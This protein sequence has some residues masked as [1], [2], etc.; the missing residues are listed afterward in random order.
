MADHSVGADV[1]KRRLQP[2]FP[3][4]RVI[5][6]AVDVALQRDQPSGTNEMAKALA[7]DPSASRLLTI[8]H[9]ALLHRNL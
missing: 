8:E 5:P 2:A 7:R 4:E 3:G 1:E 6:Q 9:A